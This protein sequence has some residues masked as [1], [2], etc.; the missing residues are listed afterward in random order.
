MAKRLIAVL[1]IL[2][3]A[4]ALISCGGAASSS[5]GPS[6][7]A[8]SGG[9]AAAPSSSTTAAPSAGSAAAPSGGSASA[10]AVVAPLKLGVYVPLS[11]TS[12]EGGIEGL[13]CIELAVKRINQN[14]GFN[15]APLELVVYDTLSNSEESVKIVNKLVSVD[16]V[17]I[18]LSSNM[19]GEILP[20]VP[21]LNEAGVLTVATGN[22]YTFMQPDWPF[23]FRATVNN[24]Y[25]TPVVAGMAKEVGYNT[26]SIFTTTDEAAL[27]TTDSFQKEAEKLGFKKCIIPESNRKLLKES[28]KLDIMSVK[29][30]SDVLKA[31][32]K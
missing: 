21:I 12:A 11:G 27:T 19:S 32:E 26:Y 7:P 6:A 13:K 9:Q 3:M 23:V 2:I 5:A 8:S 20:S 10:P 31:I 14:G 29:N 17:S 24:N 22:A 18:C 25:T 15:G 28:F 1:L 4:M 30:L 16:K